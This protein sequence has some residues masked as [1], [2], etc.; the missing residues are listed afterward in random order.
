M[1]GQVRRAIC[2]KGLERLSPPPRAKGSCRHT[3]FCPSSHEKG[4]LGDGQTTHP[5]IIQWSADIEQ[6]EGRKRRD[7]I[8][9]H[10]AQWNGRRHSRS[11]SDLR[12]CHARVR[13]GVEYCPR[14]YC[15]CCSARRPLAAAPLS[16]RPFPQSKI[17]LQP[18]L[19]MQ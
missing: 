13:S 9:T 7:V 11:R 6:Y 10:I 3:P 16:D 1:G 12:K 14:L 19:I 5:G 17:R 18:W 2:R 4:V 8:D 15:G